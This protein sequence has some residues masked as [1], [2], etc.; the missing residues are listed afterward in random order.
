MSSLPILV[1]IPFSHYCEKARWALRHARVDF[2]EEGH[3]PFASRVATWRHGK[4]SSVP[5][6]ARG[7]NGAGPPLADSTEILR[8][9][10]ERAPAGRKLYPADP[11]LRREV[12]ELEDRFDTVLGPHMRRLAYSYVLPDRKLLIEFSSGVPGYERA[13]LRVLLPL[14]RAAIKKGLKVDA[15]G[16]AR[17]REKIDAELAFVADRLAGGKPYLVG[18]TFSAADLTFAALAAPMLGPEGYGAPVPPLE[19]LPAEGQADVLRLRAT[20]AGRFALRIYDE[21]RE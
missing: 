18:D 11:A 10:D 21:H 6:L 13:S 17:S 16:V 19:R 3:L 9:A 20:T 4:W 7:G 1:T 8:W 12:C 5:L 2:I 15:A 14:A